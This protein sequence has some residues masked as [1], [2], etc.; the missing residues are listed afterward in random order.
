MASASVLL[1]LGGLAVN[2]FGLVLSL[3]SV[4]VYVEAWHTSISGVRSSMSP[5][6]LLSG[7]LFDIPPCFLTTLKEIADWLRLASPVDIIYNF[8]EVKGFRASKNKNI[9][10]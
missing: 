1:L 3:S 5:P 4:I 10:D 8:D 6:N 7:L 9:P 2:K